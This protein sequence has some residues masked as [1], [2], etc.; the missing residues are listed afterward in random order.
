MQNIDL[1]ESVYILGTWKEPLELT[2]ELSDADALFVQYVQELDLK[3]ITLVCEAKPSNEPSGNTAQGSKVSNQLEGLRGRCRSMTV[4]MEACNC[5][6]CLQPR[7]KLEQACRA[8]RIWAVDI[9]GGDAEAEREE[10]LGTRLRRTI[11][12]SRRV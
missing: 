1:A 9:V 7:A 10:V 3:D 4:V 12:A 11:K 8:A 6:S 2:F 5:S